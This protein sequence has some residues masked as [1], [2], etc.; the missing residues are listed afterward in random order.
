MR[1]RAPLD[2]FSD[3][4]P[5]RLQRR[6]RRI[7]VFR[8]GLR[9]S[10]GLDLRTAT[11]TTATNSGPSRSERF[12]YLPEVL[13]FIEV[14]ARTLPGRRRRAFESLK[15]DAIDAFWSVYSDFLAMAEARA[16]Q[17]GVPANELAAALGRAILLFDPSRKTK[18]VTYLEKTLRESI[19][20][21]RGRTYAERLLI[22][23]SAGRLVPQILWLLDQASMDKG[24]VLSAEQSERLVIGFLREHRSRFSEAMMRRIAETLLRPTVRHGFHALP[25]TDLFDSRNEVQS[26]GND[27]WLEQDEEY[28]W[29]LQQIHEATE[30]VGMDDNDRT[31]I[32]SR[33]DLPHDG[34]RFDRIAARIS[35]AALRKRIA[36]LLV[37]LSAARYAPQALRFGPLLNTTPAGA[38]LTLRTLL[39]DVANEKGCHRRQLVEDVLS[40]MT[41]SDSVY[42][43]SIAERG[44]LLEYLCGDSRTRLAGPTFWKLKAALIQFERTGG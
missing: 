32:L 3:R 9:N 41:L 18:F 21:I 23:V 24:D 30:R 1:R 42:R 13:P 25:S 15:D 43:I 10:F 29:Q 39:D 33:L 17:A 34:R 20:N 31:L 4:A 37:R 2:D 28:R 38:W 6:L 22:P 16:E 7:D 14:R 26:A 5:G 8:I 36:R 27:G 44:T 19:K 40:E 12:D 35:D 11:R